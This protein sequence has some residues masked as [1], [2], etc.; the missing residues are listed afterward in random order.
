MAVKIKRR[1][2]TSIVILLI[3]A[4]GIYVCRLAARAYFIERNK[5]HAISWITKVKEA[6]NIFKSKH[7]RYGTLADLA[8]SEVIAPGWSQT[9]K[10]DYTFEVTVTEKGYEA[11]AIPATVKAYN[12]TYNSYFLDESGV[13]RRDVK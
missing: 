10:W 2:I 8:S 11:S 5:K 9:S 3:F 6:Q 13:I 7:G 12:V 1:L 4:S